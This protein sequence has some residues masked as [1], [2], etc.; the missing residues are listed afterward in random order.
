MKFGLCLPNYGPAT[1][2]EAIRRVA[3]LADDAG[4][5]S[6]WTTDHVLVP[7]KHGDT[8]GRIIE[9]LV[10]LGYLAGI[11]ENVA[12]CTSVLV[13]P[14]RDPILIAKQVTA[15]DKL[16]D[17]RVILGVGVGWMREEYRFLR[18][19][20]HERGR[21]ADEWIAVMRQ[22]WTQERPSFHG[23]WIE[24][25]EAVFEPKPA[26]AGGPPIYVGGSSD[27][28]IRRAATLGDGWHPVGL[29]PA[30]LAAGVEKLREWSQRDDLVVSLRGHVAMGA[31]SSVYESSSGSR[32]Y[33][34]AG[35]P[36]EIA[37]AIANYADA[38]LNHLVCYFAHDTAD[39]LVEQVEGFARDVMPKVRAL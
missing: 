27:A 10:T 15:I 35:S 2:P 38:G 11:T 34:L 1:S 24:F 13:I 37:A 3:R 14:Q 26:Q 23:E 31:S 8:F 16:S 36:D 12:L 17:G 28:A 30:A 9:S 19:N 32:R 39:Q 4:Y 6:V 33:R 22:L 5:D 18:T 20:F 7:A 21:I 25:D 29:E